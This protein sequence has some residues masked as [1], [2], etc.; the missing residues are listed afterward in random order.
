MKTYNSAEKVDILGGESPY[1]QARS[2]LTEDY[3]SDY[4]V[5]K[6]LT[7]LTCT[8][9]KT[10]MIMVTWE[11]TLMPLSFCP[12]PRSRQKLHENTAVT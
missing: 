7:S 5:E 1:S 8:R 4:Q 12:R 10:R 6:A 9:M 2:L 11:Q 3:E